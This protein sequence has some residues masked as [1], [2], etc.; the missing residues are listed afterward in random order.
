MLLSERT[1]A[2]ERASPWLV[3]AMLFLFMLINYA[4][5]AILGLAAEPIMRDLALDARSFGLVG[6]AFFLCFSISALAA[7]F[8]VNRLPSRGV[9][10]WLAVAW[11]AAQAPM[12]AGGGFAALL[13]SRMALG[14]GEGPAYPAALHCAYK[15]FPDA[16]RTLPTAVVTQGSAMGIVLAGPILS[17]IILSFGWRMAFAALCAAGLAW[18]AAWFAIGRRLGERA[19]RDA[20]AP[21]DASQFD[22]SQN[23]ASRM[24][25][26]L[27]YRRLIFNPTMM[28]L[29]AAM[30]ASAWTL[31]LLIV[32]FP[33]FLRGALETPETRLG[34]LS[35]VP[36]LGGALVVLAVGWVSQRLLLQRGSSRQ[37]RGILPCGLGLCGAV[38][39][40]AAGVAENA[41][42]QFALVCFGLVLPNAIV[43]PA[44]AAMAEIA[45]D[46]QRAAV[47]SIGN[48][49][50]GLAGVVA[51]YASGLAI[52]AA[53]T[54]AQ[55]FSDAFLLCAGA[56]AAGNALGLWLIHPAREAARL[57]KTT[58]GPHSGSA[59][60]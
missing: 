22:A 38:C 43:A 1:P 14:A 8:L 27:P 51:P 4:D 46:S 50:A 57:R 25:A 17:W 40:A 18:S 53:A 39:L 21:H 24:D 23:A 45:P 15:L 42:M 16:R 30:F 41:A 31:S 12:A 56:V 20:P 55:G 28:G 29:W 47:L 49:V 11:S 36:W 60:A 32:W 35:A 52:A 58:P 34:L 6:S 44:Q 10:F 54:P 19:A 59:G 26:P 13:V 2:D 9:L 48:A 7:G 33:A 3:V 5:R 37:A